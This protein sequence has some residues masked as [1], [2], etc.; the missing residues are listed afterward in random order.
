MISIKFDSI[1]IKYSRFGRKDEKF[2]GICVDFEFDVKKA[3][4]SRGEVNSMKSS[5]VEHSK[6][7]ATHVSSFEVSLKV[8]S[9][10]VHVI[11][12]EHVRFIN[13]LR[14]KMMTKVDWGLEK[15]IF[16]Y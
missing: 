12:I 9:S 7:D 14:N 1:K 8:F 3:F 2:C 11:F 6:S 16:N 5:G 15:I 4:R 13:E 10:G